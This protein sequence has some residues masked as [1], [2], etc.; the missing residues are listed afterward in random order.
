[1]ND[2]AISSL[3]S[4]LSE[5]PERKYFDLH[6]LSRYET[7]LNR[8]LTLEQHGFGL[9]GP[10]CT[11]G[12]SVN[13]YCNT[14]RSEGGW[15]CGCRTWDTEEGPT[16]KLFVPFPLSVGT[17]KPALSRGVDCS[18]FI[19]LIWFNPR[20]SF[21]RGNFFSSVVLTVFLNYSW[22]TMLCQSLLYSMVTCSCTYIHSLS[23]I[24]FHHGLPQGVGY[25]SLCFI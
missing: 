3:I 18:C 21:E 2:S 13:V 19:S 20:M 7:L 14:T 25:S 11:W 22:F 23:Y 8:Q 4:S 9:R 15:I 6:S 12:F 5:N 1:M 16:V 24:V 17:A 10:I